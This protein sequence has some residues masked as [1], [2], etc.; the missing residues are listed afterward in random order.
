MELFVSWA[1]FPL[2]L[3]LV[4]LGC[5]LLVRAAGVEIAPCLLPGVGWPRRSASPR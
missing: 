3:L 1:L 2:A 5:G 4:C